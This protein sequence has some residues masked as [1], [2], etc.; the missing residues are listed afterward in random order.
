MQNQESLNR[1]IHY[2]EF[3]QHMPMND[4]IKW[5]E[6]KIQEFIIWCENQKYD[7]I[8]ISFSGGKDST[9]LL[10]IVLK[11][12]KKLNS[13]IYL[14]PSYAIEITFPSTIKFI[15]DV[16]KKYQANYP[17]LK[18]PFF[19]KPK[20]PW[21]D[22]LHEK[23]FPIYSKQVSVML[24]RLKRSKT[25]TEL[26]Q[27]AFGIKPSARYKLS[28]YRLFLLDSEMTYFINEN[29][30]K[31]NY[32]FSEKCCDYVKGGLKHDKRPSF[33][34][35]MANES[36]LRKQSWIKHGCNIFNKHHP[37]SRPLSLWNTDDIW[38]YIKTNQLAINE[39]YGYN[40]TIHN[41]DSL[42]FSRLGCTSCPL[43]SSIEEYIA[44]K[45]S[46]NDALCKE[47]KYRNRFEKLYEYMPNLYQTQ[48]WKT[49]MYSII[50][51]MNIKIRNDDKYMDFFYKRRKQI[52]LW[53]EN[54]HINLLRV[55]IQIEQS[56][57]NSTNW[58]YTIDDF[59]KAL[60][61]Y[62]IPHTT[63]KKQINE[64][65]KKEKLLKRS[66]VYEKK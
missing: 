3:N 8:L 20:R 1:K 42:R 31:V 29:N 12:H 5:A 57:N 28:Y 55:M 7:E 54:I 4:K 13:K 44:N 22:I 25:K 10:D 60:A 47:Y 16:V 27:I 19:V 18:D 43:G 33:I 61:H 51:D 9:V 15:R 58:Q 63:N 30:Q 11:T 14:I 34:G 53:Y 26:C 49:G 46:K 40:A 65:R 32:F 59:N 56:E 38:N 50:A 39:A 66:G 41:I 36:L 62:K 64:L 6:Q 45:H 24:N 52:N 37:M 35:T 2:E 17:F 21:I 23:G 48:I